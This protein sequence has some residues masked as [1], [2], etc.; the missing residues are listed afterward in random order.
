MSPT[1]DT[2]AE[3][4]HIRIINSQNVDELSVAQTAETKT[5]NKHDRHHQFQ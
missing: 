2:M 4:N 1:Q 5:T 3:S